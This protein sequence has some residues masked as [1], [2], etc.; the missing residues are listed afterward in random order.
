MGSWT[1]RP[2]QPGASLFSELPVFRRLSPWGAFGVL[3]LLLCSGVAAGSAACTELGLFRDFPVAPLL[4]S[5]VPNPEA[6]FFSCFSTLLLNAALTLLVLFFLGFSALGALLIP[7]FLVFKGVTLGVGVFFYLGALP[8]GEN[9][10]LGWACCA[11]CYIPA[12]AALCLFFLFFAVCAVAFSSCLARAGFSTEDVR[13]D[14]KRYG[15]DLLLFLT[16]SVAA[17]L[18]GGLAAAA[19]AV[20]FIS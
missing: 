14:L 3:A 16:L 2:L 11:L 6:G 10:F 15:R 20:F 12:A 18:L 5:G 1:D 7:G 17:S 9:S 4:F 8:E 13:R 19:Y